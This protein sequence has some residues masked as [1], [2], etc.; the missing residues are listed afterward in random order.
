MERQRETSRSKELIGC[1]FKPNL[2]HTNL[3]NPPK[4]P[5]LDRRS[6]KEIVNSYLQRKL[7]RK[8]E[9][10]DIKTEE[11]ELK[12]RVPPPNPP[13]T[14]VTLAS[15]RIKKTETPYHAPILSPSYSQL[16]P[17]Y[18]EFRYQSGQNMSK[19]ITTARPMVDYKF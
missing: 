18:T 15:T 17:Y 5:D 13:R 3:K 14:A 12:L 9:L 6:S 8:S 11:L 16:T 10:L 19:F 4:T 2:L 7:N 1:T